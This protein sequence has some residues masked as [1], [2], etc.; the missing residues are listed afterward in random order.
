ME[1]LHK[2][3]L[4]H[5]QSPL[6]ISFKVPRKGAP[7]QVPLSEPHRNRCSIP[8]T[9]LYLSLKVPGESSPP[10]GSP[11]GPLWGEMLITR[12]FCTY[13]SESPVKEP[14]SRFPSQSPHRDAQSPKHAF[15]QLSKAWEGSPLPGSPMG[16]PWKEMPIPRAF[17][18]S[19][20]S[21]MGKEIRSPS[22]EPHADGR[23]IYSGVRP[24]SPRGSFWT[25][26]L[27]T[28][29]PCSLRYDT[30]HLGLGRPESR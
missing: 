15:T 9:F 13:P 6:C 5:L 7:L 2:E 11:S 30:L 24:G 18:H 1:C 22:T 17:I 21:F 4:F 28:P 19:I 10:P 25:L 29:V 27:T 26:L 8:R 14:S 12:A 23:P 20:H 16:H 3:R